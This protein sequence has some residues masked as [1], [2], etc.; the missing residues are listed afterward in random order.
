MD[1][2][3]MNLA[4]YVRIPIESNTKPGQ[5]VVIVTDTDIDPLLWTTVASVT[6]SHGAQPMI[7]MMTPRDA[8]GTDP[9]EPIVAAVRAADVF[10][11]MTTRA[12]GHAA[13]CEEI[14][15]A[16]KPAIYMNGSTYDILTGGAA[17]ADYAAME[18][19]GI[20][21]MEL[22]NR[23]DEVRV[24]SRLGTD[25]VARSDGRLG[26]YMAARNRTLPDGRVLDAA[27]PDGEAG[28]VPLEGSGE[29]VVVWDT[30]VEQIGLLREPVKLTVEKGWVVRIEGGSQAKQVQELLEKYGDRNSYNCP[31][32]IS[33]GLNPKARITGF[34]REDKK[35]WGACHIAFGTNA[36]DG[37]VVRAKLHI[38]GLIREPTVTM[39]GQVVV[40]DGVIKV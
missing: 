35:K 21:L 6:E 24:T 3:M 25:L 38:D 32:E 29:G 2:R 9:T 14:R 31:A 34:M 36:E 15:K 22:W 28:I 37:G 16:G 17:T 39:D 12:L 33:I 10:I 20:R 8:Y 13:V 30:T 7:F 18:E 1:P 40:E 19:L 27:F 11:D 26:Y 23:C 5:K 4:R